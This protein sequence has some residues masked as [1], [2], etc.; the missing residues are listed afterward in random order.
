MTDRRRQGPAKGGRFHLPDQ[1]QPTYAD[2]AAEQDVRA[3]GVCRAIGFHQGEGRLI[4]VAGQPALLG[5]CSTCGLGI[6]T[7][8]GT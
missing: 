1:P 7:D 4:S 6:F 2:V 3:A 8:D 5:R